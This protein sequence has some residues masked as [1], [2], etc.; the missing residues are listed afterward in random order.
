MIIIMTII[1]M[2]WKVRDF[3][4]DL[5]FVEIGYWELTKN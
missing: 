4:S 5:L 3:Y 1:S 2:N